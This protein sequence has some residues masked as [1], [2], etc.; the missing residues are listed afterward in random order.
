LGEAEA[1]RGDYFVGPIGAQLDRL[2]TRT[3]HPT[4]GTPPPPR[5]VRD[6]APHCQPP[7]NAVWGDGWATKGVAIQRSIVADH[8]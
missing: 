7:G 4:T 1:A 2:I 8:T 5:S 6:R 3:K